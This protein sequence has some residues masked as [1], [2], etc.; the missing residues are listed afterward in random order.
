MSIVIFPRRLKDA[1]KR[2]EALAEQLRDYANEL[3][4]LGYPRDA[5]A[6][7]GV[8]DKLE[9][10]SARVEAPLYAEEIA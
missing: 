5:L 3:A 8:T 9:T 2:G 4:A 6:L 7:F 10:I 1:A